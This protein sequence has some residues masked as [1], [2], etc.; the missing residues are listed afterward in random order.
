MRATILGWSALSGFVLGALLGLMAF[1]VVIVGGELIPGMS[2]IVGR[3]RFVVVIFSF[4]VLPMAGTL[5]G[6]LEGRLKLR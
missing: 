5:L 6:W 2:R 1:A 4:I 3:V